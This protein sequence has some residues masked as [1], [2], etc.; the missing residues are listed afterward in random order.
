[1]RLM[2][3]LTIA[4]VVAAGA[5]HAAAD[6]AGS[7]TSRHAQVRWSGG[8]LAGTTVTPE[9]C[10]VAECDELTLRIDLPRR[11]FSRPGGVQIAIR[12]PDEGQDLD[13]Y[14]YGPDGALAA[15]SA[16]I[17][18]SAESVLMRSPRNGDYRVVVVPASAD[19]L[20]Y[21]GAAEVEYLPRRRPVRDLLPDLVSLDPRS[22]R[23]ETSAYL[24]QAPVPAVPG[25]C[26]PEETAEQGARRCLRFDQI[27]GNT[28][29]GPFELRYRMDGVA[30]AQ[31]RALAQRIY[32]SDGTHRDRRADTYVFHP[33]HAH[34]HYVNFAQ[35]HLWH[36]DATGARLGTAPARSGLKNGF[37][38]VDVEN[39]GFG[40]RGDAAR[41]YVPPACTT[42]TAVDPATREVA[43]VNGIS[44][45]WADVYNWFLPG[46]YIEVSG[47]ADGFYVLETVVDPGGTIAET[48]DTN[49]ASSILIRICGDAAEIVGAGRAC[50]A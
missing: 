47:L 27:V 4:A 31:T 6:Q 12:W 20:S 10:S 45:G 36:S 48:D 33:T 29:D 9:T 14:V 39:I 25:G 30:A 43:M 40:E 15:S 35:S 21:E 24:A 44:V 5:P 7:L 49:N 23:F 38:M 37:C 41:T 32:A 19:G 46:Q 13:L 28:G 22:L 16:G 34:F 8:P 42:P 17:V 50:S 11:T 2:T 26:Y 1:M 18:S 3:S